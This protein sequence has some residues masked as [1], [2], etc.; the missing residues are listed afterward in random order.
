M[1]WGKVMMYSILCGCHSPATAKTIEIAK[2]IKATE[3][4][5]QKYRGGLRGRTRV[6]EEV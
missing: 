1:L 2:L 6:T 4:F 5:G 3:T